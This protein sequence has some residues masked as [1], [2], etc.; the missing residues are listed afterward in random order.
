M[1]KQTAYFP[2]T[3]TVS[4]WHKSSAKTSRDQAETCIVI[5]QLCSSRP[6][7]AWGGVL[8]PTDALQMLA[9]AAGCFE[10]KDCFTFGHTAAVHMHFIAPLITV[11]FV[12]FKVA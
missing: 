6:S 12:V 8:E 1:I 2:H 4:S 9:A 5:N 11:S 10:T 7:E 3:M